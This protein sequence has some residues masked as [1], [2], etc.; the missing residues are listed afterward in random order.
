MATIHSGSDA[1]LFLLAEILRKGGVVAAPTETVYG[2][3]AS[4]LNAAACR[5]IFEIKGRP[6]HDPFIV[7]VHD[8]ESADGIAVLNAAAESLAARFWP[9]PLTLVLPKRP[10]VPDIVTSGRPTVAVR[11]PAHPLLRRLLSRCDLPLAAPSANPFGY[12][13]P[14]S[15]AHVQAGLGDRIEHIL[16]GG[17][18]KIG[19]ESTIVDVRDEHSPVILRP[20]GIP[21]ED[22]ENALGRTVRVHQ[23][24]AD[25]EAS[26]PEGELAP[27]MLD[28]H[29]SPRTPVTL[30]EA[31]FTDTELKNTPENMARVCFKRPATDIG[32]PRVFWLSETGDERDAAFRL[33]AVMR[34]L[35]ASDFARIEFEPAPDTGLGL[36]INDRLRRASR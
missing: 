35:D 30:L 4:A 23:R 24:I 20:G 8:R 28:K 5:R 31:P 3:A 17:P 26:L 12:V 29:Y 34:E 10:V 13:S 16:D 33:F 22:L 15:A 1:D 7:H 14:T 18:C 9:G 19:V 27:G 25:P 21:R 36:A 6:A 2:L 32:C 11:V